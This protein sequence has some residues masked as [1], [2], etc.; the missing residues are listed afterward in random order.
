MDR[1]HDE[2]KAALNFDDTMVA[3]GF[4]SG[5]PEQR[6]LSS[7]PILQALREAGTS[8]VYAD[9]ASVEE[10]SKT[11]GI[12]VGGV[13][14]EVDGN[15]INQPLLARVLASCLD[16]GD[17]GA[18]LA[19][20]RRHRRDLSDSDALPL[21]YT[22]ALARAGSAMVKAFGG[23]RTWEVSLQL[24][25]SSVGDR[26][27][28][29]Q[30]GRYLRSMVPTCLVKVPF[31]PHAA[32]CLLT[33]RDLERQ[34]IP[35][36]LTSTFSARQVVAAALLGGATRTNIFMGRLDQGLEAEKLG[37]HVDLEA[38]RALCRLRDEAGL[39]TQLI[40]ASLHDWRSL[41]LTAGCDVYTAPTG[42][43]ASF[44]EQDEVG[45]EELSSRLETSYED[46]LG[47]AAEVERRM[48]HERIARL[49]RVEPE[50]VEF[51]LE[52]RASD[53]YRNARD[54]EALLRRFEKAG[55]GDFFHV[56]SAAEREELRRGKLPDLESPLTQRL[57][58]DTLYALLADA[59]FEKHQEQI[60]RE[61]GRRIG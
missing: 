39:E 18:W 50:F 8:H 32:E 3:L 42:V 38:Q 5:F 31:A 2:A 28:G 22:I 15:T 51:L 46:D 11:I 55:F 27:R 21:L 53:E 44:M 49:W 19:A 45:P 1:Y 59:D 48:G 29:V 41:V 43:L 17:P 61:I 34:R 9:T 58:L 14:A 47:I 40:V 16:A 52:Y 57:A 23:Q 20:L 12:E 24:H 13:V 6:K 7:S 25:M 10:L 30:W 35:V 4:S 33:A 36:N 26:R 54:G 60:D 37:A 56:P